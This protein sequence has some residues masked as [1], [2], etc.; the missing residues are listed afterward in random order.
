MGFL[1]S[2]SGIHRKK[3]QT[4]MSD[5]RKAMF[6]KIMCN[7][8]TNEDNFISSFYSSHTLILL[9]PKPPPFTFFMHLI[10]L[11]NLWYVR[12][13]NI[14]MY[15]H[16]YMH[17]YIY[18][19]THAFKHPFK[20]TRIFMFSNYTHHDLPFL[21]YNWQWYNQGVWNDGMGVPG[22]VSGVGSGT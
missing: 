2:F 6:E 4:K 22:M 8:F 21:S 19:Y 11:L 15:M 7:F 1:R 16:I 10:H 14:I 9:T 13:V 5:S 18:T 17:T 20:Q 3:K 12:K